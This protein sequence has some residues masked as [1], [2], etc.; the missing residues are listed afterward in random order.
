MTSLCSYKIAFMCQSSYKSYRYYLDDYSGKNNN[1]K[2]GFGQ[3]YAGIKNNQEWL[4]SY[5]VCKCV[6]KAVV[7]II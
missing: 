4:T 5:C 1:E 7:A 6:S 2:T 3:P